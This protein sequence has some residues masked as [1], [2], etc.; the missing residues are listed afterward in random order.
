MEKENLIPKCLQR[1]NTGNGGK[2]GIW[3]GISD[4]G[5]TAKVYRENMRGQS[6]SRQFR[7]RTEAFRGKISEEN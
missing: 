6:V 7:N 3:G 1:T 2:V 5:T 4:F